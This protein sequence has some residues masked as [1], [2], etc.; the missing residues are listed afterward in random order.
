M[1]GITKM[2]KKY[3]VDT[4]VYW[5][6][7]VDD[8]YGK[9]TFDNPVEIKCRWVD[10]AQVMQNE[11]GKE[12][13][14]TSEVQVLQKLDYEGLLFKGELKDIDVTLLA[15]PY[16]IPNVVSV[17]R[18]SAVPKLGSTTEFVRKVYVSWRRY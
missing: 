10:I 5:G 4:A 2:I 9:K 3:C 14:A 11:H 15:T 12:F 17:Y 13:L 8:G 16:E 6:N 7:P 1:S 18:Q